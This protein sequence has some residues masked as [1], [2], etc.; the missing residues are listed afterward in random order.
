MRL[1]STWRDYLATGRIRLLVA[2]GVELDTAKFAPAATPDTG[3]R[4]LTNPTGVGGTVLLRRVGA[5]VYL[6]LSA[7]TTDTG[8][9]TNVAAIPT[10]FQPDAAA[11]FN[12]RNGVLMDDTATTLR[13]ASYY[14]SNMRVL[15]FPTAKALGGTVSWPCS[16]TFP[17]TYPGT[18]A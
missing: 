9:H 8:G 1:L 14:V 12:W 18:P 17:T 6:S 11:G 7:V 13:V 10:G 2:D 3:W 5:H 4:K 15:N 16:Q